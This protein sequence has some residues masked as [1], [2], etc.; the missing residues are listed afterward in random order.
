MD[1][2]ILLGSKEQICEAIGI[3]PTLF[4]RWVERGLPVV[5]IDGRWTGY[6]NDI[7]EFISAYIKQQADEK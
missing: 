3:G 2:P 7:A 6:K 4:T 5:K 1:K